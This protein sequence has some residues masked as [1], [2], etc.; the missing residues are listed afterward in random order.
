[1]F[2][3][4]SFLTSFILLVTVCSQAQWQPDVRLT[5]NSAYSAL[6]YNNARNIAANGSVLHVVFSDDR[7]GNPEIYYK[8]ST[9]AGASWGAETRLT[10]NTASSELPSVSVSGQVVHIVWEDQRDGNSEIYYKRSTDGGLTWG[11]D[12][13]LTNNSADSEL[14]SVSVS[15]MVVHIA[16]QDMR[17]GNWEIYYKRSTDSGVS[18][19]VDTR[20]TTAP[21]ESGYP[22]VS[23]SGQVVHIAWE[24][25]RD[26]NYEIYYKHSL[27]GGVN[28]G[29]DI[30]LSNEPA[31]SGDP[32]V[33]VS[34]QVVHVIW[35]DDRHS[36][37]HYE[38]YYKRSTDGGLSWGAET[39]LTN[40][41]AN[42]AFASISVS[43]LDVHIAWHD[44]R[45]GNS[46]IYYKR[47]AD[48]GVNWGAD[49]RLTNNSAGSQ[50]PSV[51]VAGSVVHVIW[52][53]NRDGNNEIYYKQDSP[54]GIEEAFLNEN[55]IQIFPNPFSKEISIISSNNEALEII[56]YDIQSRKLLRREFTKAVNLK[57]SELANGI[58]FYELKTKNSLL[59]KGK[60][61]KN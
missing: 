26:G 20:L 28:W 5:N 38:I 55:G 33:A 39:R 6:S 42:S 51:A 46:E 49:T 1:M 12:T 29:G 36:S 32:C 44:D 25:N 48:G 52:E 2:M 56:I 4:K 22:S 43:G 23:I 24:D 31:G 34:G 17:D 54:V 19:G 13:R 14:P 30:R 60:I 11:A 9:N 18:W 61:M 45:D 53:D 16:W 8:R 7:D 58:Y 41:S 15:G 27:D 47:S 37:F 57:T 3:K 10:N 35:H 59:S 50:F 21:A 40:N